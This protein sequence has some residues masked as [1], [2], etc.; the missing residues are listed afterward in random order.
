MLTEEDA[1]EI[2]FP[3]DTGDDLTDAVN[4]ALALAVFFAFRGMVRKAGKRDMERFV[5][6]SLELAG[7]GQT[8]INFDKGSRWVASR[9]APSLFASQFSEYDPR[10]FNFA[11]GHK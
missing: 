9:E 8:G 6:A 3:K 5:D 4:L 7:R 10:G 2:D 1:A 11:A